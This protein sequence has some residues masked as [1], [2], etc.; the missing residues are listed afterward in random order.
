MWLAM[1]SSIRDFITA[2]QFLTCIQVGPPGEWSA[3]QCGR[4]VRYFPLVGAAIGLV[5]ALVNYSLSH[6]LL[7]HVSV[8]ILLITEIWLTGALHFDGFMDTAD[9][10][11]SHRSRERMLDIMRD[12]R[13]G[14]HA[15]TAFG[16]LLLLKY[17]LLLDLAPGALPK[18]LFVMPIAGR[19][20]MVIAITSFPMARIDGLGKAFSECSGRWAFPVAALL[21]FALVAPLG[22]LAILTCLSACLL[23]FGLARWLSGKL[24]GLTGDT[25]GA[26]N[27]V[28]QAAVLLFW[29]F[30]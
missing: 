15:V 3:E 4:S 12:S 16:V 5:L 24:G 8:M 26:V 9:G 23:G 19:M 10:I 13:V 6:Y 2:L 21:T 11:F 20:A 14:V 30:F 25:Y 17:S 29:L 1:K 7:P 27:E 18:A 28:T 22:W